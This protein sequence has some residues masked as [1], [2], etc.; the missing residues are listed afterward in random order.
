MFLRNVIFGIKQRLIPTIVGD[1]AQHILA[2]ALWGGNLS[3]SL[4]LEL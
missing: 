3:W 4:V 2:D 1:D